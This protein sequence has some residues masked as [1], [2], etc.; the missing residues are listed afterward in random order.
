MATKHIVVYDPIGLF[1]DG[2][3]LEEE[4]A[5]QVAA[6]GVVT[7]PVETDLFVR[8]GVGAF[9]KRSWGAGWPLSLMAPRPVCPLTLYVERDLHMLTWA[10]RVVVDSGSEFDHTQYRGSL[11]LVTDGQQPGA[12]VGGIS[13]GNAVLLDPESLGEADVHGGWIVRGTAQLNSGGDGFVGLTLYGNAPGL[14]VAW[15]A[16]ALSR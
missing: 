5:K 6:R 10:A 1:W 12:Q 16:V 8:S 4:R 7:L 14:R 15:A 3:L 13:D 2:S 11:R 9:H